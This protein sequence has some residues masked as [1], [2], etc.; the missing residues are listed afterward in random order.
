M[1]RRAAPWKQGAKESYPCRSSKLGRPF[2]G[3]TGCLSK[4]VRSQR[5][6]RDVGLTACRYCQQIGVGRVRTPNIAIL[7]T[8]ERNKELLIIAP[9]HQRDLIVS[10]SCCCRLRS[11]GETRS[12]RSRHRPQ[13]RKR[14]DRTAAPA[15]APTCRLGQDCG[16]AMRENHSRCSGYR[17]AVRPPCQRLGRFAPW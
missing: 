1:L 8:V 10:Q 6:C 11:R 12:M 15:N 7:S 2:V 14:A 5:T 16:S 3:A 4:T 13:S 9:I 17:R